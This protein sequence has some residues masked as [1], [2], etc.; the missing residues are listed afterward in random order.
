MK[1]FEMVLLGHP[2]KA[3]DYIAERVAKKLRKEYGATHTSIEVAW[4]GWHLI[5]GGEC[6]AFID[7]ITKIKLE[8]FVANILRDDLLVESSKTINMR[9]SIFIA[10]QSPEIS[11]LVGKDEGA[12]D[13][14]IFFAGYD[15]KWSPI[16]SKLKAVAKELSPKYLK[17][18]GYKS[19]GKF[20]AE[21]DDNGELQKFTLNVASYDKPQTRAF[22]E[23]LRDLLQDELNC[24]S[25]AD[26]N[27]NALQINPKGDWS[28]CWG[29]AD[30]GLSGRK[31]A[32]DYQGG[33][34]PIGGGAIFGKDNTKADR[35][36]NAYLYLMTKESVG[37]GDVDRVEYS[38]KSIIGDKKIEIYNHYECVAELDFADI[39]R[40]MNGKYEIDIFGEIKEKEGD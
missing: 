7:E 23:S 3:C 16:V 32:C 20:I 33:L 13:N 8:S 39:V 6:N 21:F 24:P 26:D 11:A 34:F 40:E 1:N 28:N 10:S 12:G 36:V 38:A 27:E 18:F 19:D 17:V 22:F 5:I 35:S 29:F 15:R 31:L 30:A 37:Y 2:D 25:F 9:I 4:F 14:G